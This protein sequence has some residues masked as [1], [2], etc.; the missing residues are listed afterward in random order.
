MDSTINNSYN[1]LDNSVC[2][3]CTYA[4][5]TDLSIGEHYSNLEHTGPERQK[6]HFREG[7][8]EDQSTGMQ[9][10]PRQI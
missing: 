1:L 6:I 3:G 5:G 8:S 7:N 4:V 9:S 10:F 2:F